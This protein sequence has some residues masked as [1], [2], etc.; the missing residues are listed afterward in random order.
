MSTPRATLDAEFAA[1]S[2][3]VAGVVDDYKDLKGVVVSLDKKIEASHIAL[4]AKIDQSF[5]ALSGKF[6]TRDR[7]NWSAIATGLGVLVAV[8]V[9]IGGLALQPSKDAIAASQAAALYER[10][11]VDTAQ[12]Q[13]DKLTGM[14]S[15]LGAK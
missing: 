10:Q 8:M 15:I 4:S 1:L 11:R 9:A 14:L 3:Q 13:I 12:S 6:E 2:Q 7:I 5:T